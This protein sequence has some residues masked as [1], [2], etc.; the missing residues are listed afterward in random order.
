MRAQRG[1]YYAL[2]DLYYSIRL[3]LSASMFIL[4]I[5]CFFLDMSGCAICIHPETVS[6]EQQQQDNAIL[7]DDIEDDTR[8]RNPF[9]I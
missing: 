9:L 2:L 4:F 5:L 1:C 3:I 6:M 8:F 7:F